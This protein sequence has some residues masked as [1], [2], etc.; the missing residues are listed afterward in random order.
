MIDAQSH[1]RA[2]IHAAGSAP[3]PLMDVLHDEYGLTFQR[4]RRLAPANPE[5][6]ASATD[7]TPSPPGRWDLRVT[8]DWN[9]QDT[10]IDLYVFGPDGEECSYQRPSPRD[11]VAYSG[12][13]EYDLAIS[14]FNEAVEIKSR[15]AEA[16][17][18]RGN[19]YYAKGRFDEAISDYGKAVETDPDYAEAYYNRGNAYY[20]KEQY[21]EAISDYSK[22][23]EINSAYAE[24]Y[25]NRGV[26]Y[27]YKKEYEKALSDVAKAKNLGYE[28][29]QGFL[30]A[31][32]EAKE[33]KK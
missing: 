22:A 18:N 26:A 29:Q 2:A 20:D 12:E 21:D 10:D 23:V 16:Y 31:L 19:A 9:T 32:R 6:A 1:F 11:G 7:R 4:S 13:G 28:V 5:L 30:K 27:S 24:A 14:D 15:Y 25:F 8:A 3:S 33:R 17:F